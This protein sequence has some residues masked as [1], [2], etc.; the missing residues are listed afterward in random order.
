MNRSST[1]LSPA[2][3]ACLV[4]GSILQGTARAQ[5]PAPVYQQARSVDFKLDL[6]LRQEWTEEITFT[7]KTRRLARARPRVE[8]NLGPLQLGVGGDFTYGEDNTVDSAGAAVPLMRDNY[9]AREARLDLAW[10][11]LEPFSQLS[12]QAG[13]FFMPVRGASS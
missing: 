3:A 10:A 13:R 2:L 1:L 12:L 8:A 5:E 7:E 11:R 9:D 6:L 4:A